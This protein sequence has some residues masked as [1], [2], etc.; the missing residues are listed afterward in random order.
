MSNGKCKYLVENPTLDV[1]EECPR[2]ISHYD[3]ATLLDAFRHD[4]ILLS[5]R[6]DVIVS[7]SDHG[8]IQ[9]LNIAPYF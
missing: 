9:H 4:L 6:L 1:I 5:E 8:D 3:M 2:H 7:E